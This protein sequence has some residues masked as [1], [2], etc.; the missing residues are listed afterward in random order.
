MAKK[1]TDLPTLT[2]ADSD[3]LVPIVDISGNVTKKV[4]AGGIVPNRA[5]TK[6][7]IDSTTFAT[8][9]NITTN[10]TVDDLTISTGWFYIQGNGSTNMTGS[11]TFPQTFTS[12]PIVTVS[13]AGASGSAPTQ[14][15]DLTSNPGTTSRTVSTYSTTT[16]GFSVSLVSS[17]SVGT[18]V[19]LGVTWT[20][21]GSVA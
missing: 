15:S 11:V 5:I 10:S 7:K 16:T 9:R 3:D 6:A 13:Y 4:T 14:I 21:I 20:A 18:G 19:Y 2:S 17:A 8:R 1:I 12:P